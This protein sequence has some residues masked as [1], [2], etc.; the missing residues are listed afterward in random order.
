MKTDISIKNIVSAV[1]YRK[2]M[3]PEEWIYSKIHI[4]NTSFE[5]DLEDN[6]LPIFQINSPDVKTIITTR[7]I[8]EK[9]KDNLNSVK[10]EDIEKVIYGNFKGKPNMPEL[11]SF[12]VIDVYGKEYN[13]QMETGKASIGLINA[14]STTL[15]LR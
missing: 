5:F 12:E 3:N 10:F 15:R 7:R 13:F 8:I 6:E 11:S 4:G 9:S 1:I 2:V 14:I